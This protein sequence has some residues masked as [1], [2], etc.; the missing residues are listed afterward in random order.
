MHSA[1]SYNL[2]HIRPLKDLYRVPSPPCQALKKLDVS[3][4]HITGSLEPLRACTALTQL[5]ATHN[6]LVGGLEPLDGCKALQE[7]CN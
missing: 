7:L 2:W 6:Q 4:N 5:W 1:T 3:H